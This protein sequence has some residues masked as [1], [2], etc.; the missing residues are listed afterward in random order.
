MLYIM[1]LFSILAGIDY[2]LNNK[3]GLGEKFE[4]GFRSMGGMALSIV[5]IYTLSPIIGKL[6]VPVLQP[7]AKLLRTDPSVFMGSILAVDLGGYMTSVEVA[8]SIII[9][10]FNGLIL[11]SMLGATISFTIPVALKLIKPENQPYFSKG[12]LSGI[13]TV[14]IGMAVAGVMMKI[15]LKELIASLFPVVLFSLILVIGLIYFFDKL[16]KIFTLIGKF[17]LLISTIGLL[18]SILDFMFGIKL[19]E[20]MLPFEEAIILVGKIGVILS[21]A[22][23]LIYFISTKMKKTLYRISNKYDLNEYSILGLLSCTVNNVPMIGVYDKMNWKGQI[24][25]AA[26]AVSG[27]FVFGGQLGYVSSLSKSSVNAF[28]AAKLVGG[29]SAVILASI[30]IKIDIKKEERL[31]N[32]CK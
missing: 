20:G 25:N 2:I 28:I 26:F 8:N 6:V 17:I 19:V 5:G 9:G 29:I 7:I 30:M 10:K 18:I 21:G 4:D 32:E 12:I 23:P 22:Y 14:P 16:L 1:V 27:S 11:A 13:I 3:Y 15:S 31:N 24:I